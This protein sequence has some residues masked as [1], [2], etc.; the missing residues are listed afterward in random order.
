M[1]Q[2]APIAWHF[3][4]GFDAAAIVLAAFGVY[5]AL[6]LARRLSHTRGHVAARW[7][8]GSALAFGTA[9]AAAH[10]VAFASRP[11]PFPIG[12]GGWIT[13]AAGAGSVVAAALALGLAT[14]RAPLSKAA[15]ALLFAAAV[16]AASVHYLLDLRVAP[17]LEWRPALL[18]AAVAVLAA[19]LAVGAAQ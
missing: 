12:Y 19:A 7:L 5:V 14:Q 4:P 11:L 9:M 8:V 3:R 6:E 10:F 17:A 16:V 13:A 2:D 15:A 1:L 18:A